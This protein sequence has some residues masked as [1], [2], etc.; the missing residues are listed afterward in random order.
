MIIV[1]VYAWRLAPDSQKT[2]AEQNT[3]LSCNR[4]KKVPEV[5]VSNNVDNQ[6]DQSSEMLTQ[7]R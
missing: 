4:F 6:P 1:L 2:K 3:F 7:Q 5:T